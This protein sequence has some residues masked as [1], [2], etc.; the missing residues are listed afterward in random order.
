MT[1]ADILRVLDRL[2]MNTDIVFVAS[3]RSLWSDIEECEVE[4]R[5]AFTATGSRGLVL[6]LTEGRAP[7]GYEDLERI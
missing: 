7:S 4:P 5:A 3:N 1:K 2:P 6:L